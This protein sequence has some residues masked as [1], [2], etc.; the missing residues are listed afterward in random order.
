MVAKSCLWIAPNRLSIQEI[1]PK[2]HSL[3]TR[4]CDILLKVNMLSDPAEIKTIGPRVKKL[5]EKIDAIR[6]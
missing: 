2:A 4:R 3:G 5:A 6:T 1:L